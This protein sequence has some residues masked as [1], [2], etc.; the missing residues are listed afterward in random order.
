[1]EDPWRD[2][3]GGLAPGARSNA[4]ITQAAMAEYYTALLDA[5]EPIA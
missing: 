3:R 5:G 2:A 1:M 4:E